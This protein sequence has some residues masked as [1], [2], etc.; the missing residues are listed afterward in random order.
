MRITKFF[1]ILSHF[2]TLLPP[3]PSLV[4]PKIKILKKEKKKW[5]K[6]LEI[7][8][9]Y[10]YMCTIN[11]GHMIY[12]S[13]N[14]RCNGQKF[15]SFWVLFL[16]FQP[17]ENPKNQNFKIEKK[18]L[19]ISFY[20]FAPY[21]RIIWYMA[22]QTW[23]MTDRIVILNHFLPFYPPNSLKNQNFEKLKKMPRDIIILHMCTLNDNNMMY[24][25]WDMECD[26]QNFMSFWTIFCPFTPLKT[27]KIKILKNWKKNA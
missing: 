3:P 11:E 8:S 12:G 22:P 1:V 20:I 4:I 25:S 7:L 2:F 18:H 21:L 16:L 24:G 19:E 9:L 23:S 17:P 14:V 10:T 5:K 6:C 26:R 15:L 27:R 13:W